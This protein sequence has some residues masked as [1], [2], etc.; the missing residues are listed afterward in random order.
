MI[1]IDTIS[2]RIARLF[3]REPWWA[4]FWSGVTAV[5]WAGLSW[6]S[7]ER[8][9]QWPSMRVLIE[10]AADRSWHIAGLVLGGTQLICLLLDRRWPRWIAAFAMCWFWSV[11]AVG[12]WA[13][14]PWAPGVAVYAGWCGINM[15]CIVRLLRPRV[16]LA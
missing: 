8:L 16:F 13:A 10:L 1:E 7:V 6:G 4:E 11:L 12:V 9:G 5:L 14:L 3:Q 2:R 15:L